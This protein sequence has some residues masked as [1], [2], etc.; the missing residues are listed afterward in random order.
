LSVGIQQLKQDMRYRVKVVNLSE[1]Q[2]KADVN[3]KKANASKVDT[4]FYDKQ[5]SDFQPE[6]GLISSVETILSGELT[7]SNEL[8]AQKIAK[9]LIQNWQFEI[10]KLNYDDAGKYQCLL[11]LVKPIAKNIT[12]QVIRKKIIHFCKIISLILFLITF[13]HISNV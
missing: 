13:K 8:K 5:A 7:S 11:P 4:I 3:E 9:Y 12:L 1:Q 10:R 6:N 2:I